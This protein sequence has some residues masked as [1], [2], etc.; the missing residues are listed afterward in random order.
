M[1]E[2]S[3]PPSESANVV[4]AAS[5]HPQLVDDAKAA[6]A[7]LTQILGKDLVS[8]SLIGHAIQEGLGKGASMGG[9]FGR[10]GKRSGVDQGRLRRKRDLSRSEAEPLAF[11]AL[12]W[13]VKLRQ[14]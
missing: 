2:P 3:S 13:E 8:F 11:L 12:V 10:L 6:G 9:G 1:P 14:A 5:S 4:V 7:L